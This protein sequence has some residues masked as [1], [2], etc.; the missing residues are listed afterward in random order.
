[1]PELPEVE[2]TKTSLTPLI[3]KTVSDIYTSNYR[4]RELIPDDLDELVG[5]TLTHTDRRAKYL[6]LSF[7]KDGQKL[8]LLIHLGMS[9]SLQQ[10]KSTTPRKHDHVI[11]G[12]GD[13]HLHYHDPRRFGMVIWA[14]DGQRYLDKLGVE[15]LSD[16]FNTQYLDSFTQKTHKPIKTLIMEQPVVV[17]VGNIYAVESLFLSGIHPLTPANTLSQ[18]KLDVLVNNIKVILSRSIEQGG[19]TL[20]DFT[21][22]DGK[23]GYFQQTLLV[24]GRADEPCTICQHP[25]ENIKIGGRA[26]VY[27]PICQPFCEHKPSSSPLIGKIYRPRRLT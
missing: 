10:H 23:T 15:P 4:L 20:K 3:G 8:D 19:S 13:V 12:F 18:D 1:M 17:G 2:T 27:C 5:A 9:G 22:G 14:K 7:D 6:I 26:S 16:A 11:F 24:Y 25:L 21:V